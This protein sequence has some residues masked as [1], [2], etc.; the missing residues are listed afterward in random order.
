MMG[1]M[2]RLIHTELFKVVSIRAPV[3]LLAGLLVLTS[4]IVTPWLAG[5]G[6]EMTADDLRSLLVM[7][8]GVLAMSVALLVGVLGM[9]GEFRNDTITLTLLVTPVRGE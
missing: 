9:A 3:L 2:L 4:L 1:T 5:S 8:P 7:G 6:G